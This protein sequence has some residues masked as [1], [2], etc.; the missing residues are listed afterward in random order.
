MKDVRLSESLRTSNCVLCGRE[1]V[2]WHGTVGMLGGT[3][4][5]YPYCRR[6][7]AGLCEKHKDETDSY[8]GVYNEE[9]HGQLIAIDTGELAGEHLFSSD[10]AEIQLQLLNAD[11]VYRKHGAKYCE[12]VEK[13]VSVMSLMLNTAL[14]AVTYSQGKRIDDA[15]L[16]TSFGERLLTLKILTGNDVGQCEF[17]AKIAD[18]AAMALHGNEKVR[19][20][21]TW[22]AKMAEEASIFE[23]FL[24]PYFNKVGVPE[25]MKS[26]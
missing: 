20:G 22:A 18:K 21:A 14:R 13:Y 1:A 3:Q 7:I 25:E 24:T 11:A 6:I 9:M 8:L 16:K 4:K 12:I 19:L 17:G 23:K 2:V 10:V 5:K 15:D 26:F